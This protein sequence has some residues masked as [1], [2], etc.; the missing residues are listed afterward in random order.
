VWLLIGLVLY[1]FY[2][3]KHSGLSNANL[4]AEAGKGGPL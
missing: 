3:R 4:Q 1:Y 2:C